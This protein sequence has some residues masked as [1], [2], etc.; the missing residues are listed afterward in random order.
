MHALLS[1]KPKYVEAIMSGE[2][3]YEFR[4]SIFRNRGVEKAYIYATSPIKKIVGAFKIGDIIEDHPDNLWKQFKNSSGL[5]SR[6]FFSYF[7]GCEAGFAIQIEDF[8]EFKKPLDPTCI[9]PSFTPPQ[10]FYYLDSN[11]LSQF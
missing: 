4:R 1:I 5:N 3:E 9:I 11:M 8:E 10:S 6:E 7:N 2:K